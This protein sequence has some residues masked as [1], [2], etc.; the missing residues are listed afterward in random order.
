M[1]KIK[2]VENEFFGIRLGVS[3]VAIDQEI[4]QSIQI[5]INRLP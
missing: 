1:K 4:A 3:K 5:A 2:R